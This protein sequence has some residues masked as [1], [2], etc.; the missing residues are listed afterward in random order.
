M[1]LTTAQQKR[2]KELKSINSPIDSQ[3]KEMTELNRKKRV[4]TRGPQIKRRAVKPSPTPVPIGKKTGPYV[5]PVTPD[6]KGTV[7]N[8]EQRRRD[9]NS[10]TIPS[11]RA[12]QKAN[13][14]RKAKEESI[15]KKKS[16]KLKPTIVPKKRI[17]K[18]TVS[19]VPTGKKTGEFKSKSKPAPNTFTSILASLKKIFSSNKSPTTAQI[20][21]ALPSDGTYTKKQMEDFK[22][23]LEPSN[24]VKPLSDR[25]P[26]NTKMTNELERQKNEK[27]KKNKK[28]PTVVPPTTSVSKKVTNKEFVNNMKKVI[29]AIPKNSPIKKSNFLNIRPGR[30]PKLKPKLNPP[31]KIVVKDSSKNL[32]VPD[33]T[34]KGNKETYNRL[35]Q[36][37]DLDSG[38]SE[39]IK[40]RSSGNFDKGLATFNPG[41]MEKGLA[42]LGGGKE[43]DALTSAEDSYFTE[44]LGKRDDVNGLSDSEKDY[45]KNFRAKKGG[46]V[47]AKKK[48]SKVIAKKKG[49]KVMPKKKGGT[50]YRRGGGKALRGFGK[51]TYSNKPY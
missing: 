48:G 8:T 39:F 31:K 37:N 26:K 10:N 49:S 15:A 42:A 13:R 45:V 36:R 20:K 44:L 35:K 29:E 32:N 16:L 38:L 11:M 21:K 25:F 28:E 1:A 18:S 9:N 50:V 14:E 41:M 12:K 40:Q 34:P 43:R 5:S 2:L 24:K 46:K 27:E 47:I 17:I 3:I 22:K 30:K 23:G 6:R 4:N 51:A 7:T 33:Y 19:E